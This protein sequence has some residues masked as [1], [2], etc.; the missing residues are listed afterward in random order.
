MEEFCPQGTDNLVEWP[1]TLHL[2]VS[3]PHPEVAP[4]WQ[5]GENLHTYSHRG[6]AEKAD[7][8]SGESLPPCG[9]RQ[10]PRSFESVHSRVGRTQQSMWLRVRQRPVQTPALPPPNRVTQRNHLTLRHGAIG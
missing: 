2:P 5:Q 1:R 6:D 7:L 8:G 4:A 3:A 9:L 10:V